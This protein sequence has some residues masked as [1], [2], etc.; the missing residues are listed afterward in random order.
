VIVKKKAKSARTNE[1]IASK[2]KQAMEVKRESSK[3]KKAEEPKV[4]KKADVTK[5]SEGNSKWMG[6]LAR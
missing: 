2:I 1:R 5:G 6:E 3:A 4:N